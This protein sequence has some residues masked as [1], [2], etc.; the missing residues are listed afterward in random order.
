[1]LASLLYP[2]DDDAP[3]LID[4]WVDEWERAKIG[5]IR[6]YKIGGTNYVGIRDFLEHQRLTLRVP[7]PGTSR[8][9]AGVAKRVVRRSLTSGTRHGHARGDD[10]DFA[11]VTDTLYIPSGLSEATVLEPGV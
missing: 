4:G 3:G 9:F 7:P 8:G 10:V 1:M 11:A 6:R 2:F 5:C